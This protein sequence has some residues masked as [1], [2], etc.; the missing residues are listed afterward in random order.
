MPDPVIAYLALGSNL[1]DRRAF[2]DQALAALRSAARHPGAGR[3]LLSRHGAGRRSRGAGE[4]SQRGRPGTNHARAHEA[5]AVLLATEA[6]MGRAGASASVRARSISICCCTVSRLSTCKSP[7]MSCWCRIRAC[8]NGCLCWS[9]WSKLPRWRFIRCC[10][11][12]PRIYCSTAKSM[13]KP[14]APP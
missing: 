7:A 4:L 5:L 6:Q 12:R 3:F 9:R 11:A 8:T 2:L 10:K 13:A 14:T 1:G